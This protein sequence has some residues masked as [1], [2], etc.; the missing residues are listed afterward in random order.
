MWKIETFSLTIA[1]VIDIQV[2]LK[3]SHE[4][5]ALHIKK[6]RKSQK[7]FRRD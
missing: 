6:K 7:L 2:K 4:K 1:T 3:S 5:F